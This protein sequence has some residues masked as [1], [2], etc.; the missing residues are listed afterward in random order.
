MTTVA[1]AAV[2]RSGLSFSHQ[3]LLNKE[4]VPDLRKLTDAVH[5]EGAACSIQIGHCG[6][7]ASPSV[8]GSRP[9]APSARVNLYGPAFPRSL[10]RLRSG[11]W[12]NLLAMQFIQPANQASML[13]KFMRVMATS[14]VSFFH[15]I[16]TEGKTH[17]EVPW[18]TG[19]DLW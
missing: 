13:L 4:A 12:Q 10:I 19:P 9:V 11:H 8:T 6:N 17:L 18:K 3:L 16:P 15:H 5:K 2:E 7:M 14:S 1:Y